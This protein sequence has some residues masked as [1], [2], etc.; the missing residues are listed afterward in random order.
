[1][2]SKI[3]NFRKNTLDADIHHKNEIMEN[4]K[5]LKTQ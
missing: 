3:Q 2:I 4:G 1:M 5:L